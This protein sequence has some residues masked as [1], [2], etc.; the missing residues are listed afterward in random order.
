VFRVPLGVQAVRLTASVRFTVNQAEAFLNVVKN[1]QT[2]PGMAY[3]WGSGRILAATSSVLLVEPGDE[4]R[5]RVQA[6]SATVEAHHA[7][8]L[9][10]EVVE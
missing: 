2:H 10:I 5:C 6:A 4:F 8:W 3:A 7:T 1:G 9:S